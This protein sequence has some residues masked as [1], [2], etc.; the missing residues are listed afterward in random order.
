MLDT[1]EKILQKQREIIFSKTSEERFLIG[2][3]TIAFG[4]TIVESSIKRLKPNISEINLKIAVFKRY[5]ENIF[6]KENLEKI[7]SSMTYYYKHRKKILEK[8][9][10]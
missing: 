1:K 10:P 7:I 5:Y 6:S 4:R 9:T 2:V 8:S 3:E